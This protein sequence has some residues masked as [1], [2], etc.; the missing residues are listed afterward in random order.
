MDKFG[1]R[2]YACSTAGFSLTD[3][4]SNGHACPECGGLFAEI[5]YKDLED[6]LRKCFSAKA[7]DLPGMWHYFD[8]LPLHSLKHIVSTGEGGVPIDRWSFLENFAR[9]RFTIDCEVYAHR[10]D[11]NSATGSFKDLSGSLVA[12]VLQEN[13]IYTYVAASTGNIGVAFARYISKYKGMLYVFIPS[14]SSQF[15][16]A[17]ISVFGQRVFRISGTYAHA[18]QS[19]SR[20]AANHRILRAG[21]ASDPLRVEAKKTMSFE[22]QRQMRKFPTAYIQAL[23][24]GTG[25]IGTSKG[26]K[27]LLKAGLIT[28]LPRQLLV[29]SARCA[30]MYH[31]W[32]NSQS[33]G[34]IPGWQNKY[35]VYD[36]PDTEIP[37]LATGDPVC[38]PIVSNLVRESRGEILTFPEE[39]VSHIAR[40][41]AFETAV[42]IGPAAAIAVGGF[43][44]ALKNGDICSEDIVLINIG[45]G[46]RR[47]PEFMARLT[48]GNK[49]IETIEDCPLFDR[50]NYRNEIWEPL[51]EFSAE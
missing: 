39:L 3:W 40:V 46:I 36:C 8:V 43:F 23:S 21:E 41:V 4:L 29:Q 24:G 30:P 32:K 44:S 15:K 2:C 6:R 17:E 37:T 13:N 38:Y 12:S 22:W 18:K 9:E 42:R 19:A 10:Q 28:R 14:N 51:Y 47:D 7:K 34:F 45:E 50:N 48:S 16:E 5:E 20:F 49:N 33:Q 1:L 31:A 25:S 27:E 35:P 26:C 11:N